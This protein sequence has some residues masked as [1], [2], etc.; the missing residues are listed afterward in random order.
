MGEFFIYAL[1]LKSTMMVKNSSQKPLL[2]Y[3]GDCRL[4]R[5]FI[6]QWKRKTAKKIDYEPFQTAATRYP[7]IPNTNFVQSIQLILPS[8][9]VR[10]GA[11][12]IFTVYHYGGGNR[13]IS[14]Y[15]HSC[16]FAR[17]AEWGYA[18]VAR[19]RGIFGG[20]CVTA[21]APRP[22]PQQ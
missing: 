2:I 22:T 10:S 13:L 15:E 16:L 20:L 4:C 9:E 7:E 6:E 18:L 1:K 11:Y 17:L 8:G 19:N 5:C 14:L 3:D 21:D 12:A